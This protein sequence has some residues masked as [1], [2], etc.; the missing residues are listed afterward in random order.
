M[1]KNIYIVSDLHLGAPNR[2]SSL[3]REKIFVE[4]L[5]SIEDKAEV[6]YLV[7]DIFDF[8][9]EY[10]KTVPQGY[11][12]LLGKLAMMSD[13]GIQIHLFTGN[14]DLWYGEYLKNEIGAQIHTG[15]ITVVHFGQKYYIA[16]GDGL[17]PGDYGYKFIKAIFVNPICQWLF[18]RLHPDTGVSLADFFSKLSGYYSKTDKE[19]AFYG[20]EDNLIIHSRSVLKENMDYNFFVFGHRHIVKR[21]L[22]SESSEVIYLGDWLKYFSYVEITAKT[23]KI[24][25]L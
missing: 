1:E 21:Y 24:L 25:H 18:R 9:F 8:W 7:G 17:G 10:R 11:V 3:K 22:L 14:H 5:E 4:W 12:R 6:L 13:K 19:P 20:E 23:V 16:H 15:P 2:E